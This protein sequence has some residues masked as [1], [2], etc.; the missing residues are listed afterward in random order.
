VDNVTPMTTHGVLLLGSTGS[1]E[2]RR[3]TRDQGPHRIGSRSPGLAAGG[4]PWSCWLGQVGEFRC[5]GSRWPRCRRGRRAAGRAARTGHGGRGAGGPDRSRPGRGHPPDVVLRTASTGRGGCG[6]H[7]PRCHLRVPPWRLANK[8]SLVAGGP[9]VTR[10]AAPGADRPGGLRALALAQCLRG[11]RAKE[12]DPRLVLTVGGRSEAA[13]ATSWPMSA[14]TT[15]S[16]TPPGHGP[17]G[18]HQL[19]DP[20][21]QG[22]G[23]DRGHTCCSCAYDRIDVVV[24]PQSVIHSMVTFTDGATIAQAS[25]D[26]GPIAAPCANE[27]HGPARLWPGRSSAVR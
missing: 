2:P 11:G 4:A 10:A 12:V 21:E 24:H 17:G 14:W 6:R 16:S 8:E 20:G 25:A 19:G 15:R 13:A 18:H 5:P 1:I 27:P 7:W 26:A 23:A 9:L 3:W 22:A